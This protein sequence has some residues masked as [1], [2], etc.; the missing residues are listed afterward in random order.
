MHSV[1]AVSGDPGGAN[2]LAPVLKTLRDEGRATVRAL[3]YNEARDVWSTHSI[4]FEELPRDISHSEIVSKLMGSPEGLLLVGTSVNT[5]ELEKQFIDAAREIAMPSLAVLDFWSG[6]RARFSNRDG[7]LA[8]LPDRIA[9]MDDVAKEEMV[10]EGFERHRVEVTG[11]PAFDDLA[12]YRKQF[13]AK[14]RKQIRDRLQVGVDDLLVLFA[15]QPLAEVSRLV[16]SDELYFGFNEREVLRQL[17]AA[18]ERISNRTRRKI[19]LLVRPHPREALDAFEHDE[20]DLV[21]IVVSRDDDARK[22][23]MAAD[24]VTGM[25]TVLLV[26][27]CYLGCIVVSLQ[28]GL[29]VRDPLPTNRFEL[30]YPVY[31]LDQ[32]APV[33]EKMLFDDESRKKAKAKLASF[34]NDGGAT[35]RV[36]DLTYQMM[37]I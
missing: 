22:V 7:S 25:N 16:V 11:Q 9:V 30:S 31:A 35:R 29:T 37:G 19:T 27:A 33:V 13:S 17:I 36:V 32:I 34:R 2:A 14:Q 20:R 5:F 1:I 3:A 10:Q 6:Y 24:L 18:L 15:S 12:G 23:A 21:R 4:S 26:E 8:H 28:P